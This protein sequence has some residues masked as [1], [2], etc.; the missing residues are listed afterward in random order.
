MNPKPGD[1]LD[2]DEENTYS[3]EP[4]LPCLPL[5]SQS[6]VL[7]DAEKQRE[8]LKPFWKQAG[9][10]CRTP[11]KSAGELVAN[12]SKEERLALH[13]YTLS[14]A[15]A[16]A[17]PPELLSPEEVLN[18]NEPT[19]GDLTPLELKKAMRDFKR[20]RQAYRTKV[21]TKNKSQTQVTR[22]II[23]NMMVFFGA[24]EV[25]H[26]NESN[27]QYS[28]G[29]ERKKLD[30]L[31]RDIRNER[32]VSVDSK[33]RKRVDSV[34]YEYKNSGKLNKED[35]RYSKDKYSEHR[36]HSSIYDNSIRRTV[37]VKVNN[38]EKTKYRHRSSDS[39][40]A[41]EDRTGKGVHSKKRKSKKSKHKKSKSKKSHRHKYSSS[42]DI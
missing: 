39:T 20:R 34:H 14:H 2:K 40:S 1:I 19:S 17:K 24:E 35:E 29:D 26:K 21:S 28:H 16:V 3:E 25:E 32:A 23:H 37:D 36:K 18:S 38:S 31:S 5:S 41:E 6:G 15:V 10:D 13:E 11:P 4:L 8:I 22:E 7:I 33:K 42:E 9:P 27:M 30:S 12:F